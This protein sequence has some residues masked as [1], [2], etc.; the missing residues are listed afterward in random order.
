MGITKKFYGKTLEGADV[1]IF[2]LSNSKGMTADII[3]LG[4]IVVSL[5]VPDKNGKLEDVVLGYDSIEGYLKPG[6]YFGALVGRH[7]NRIE[8]SKFE[9]NGVE[10]SLYKNN[11]ENHLHGGL[12][13]FDKV[14]WQA[15]IIESAGNEEL[16]LT[17]LSKDG[18]EGYPGNLAVKVIYALTEDNALEIKYYAVSDK[19]TV[20][21]LTNHSYFNLSGHASGD[22]LEH[23]IMI[24][25]D[26]F[27]VADK[28]LIPT[29]E[30]RSVKGT[31]MDLTKLTPISAGIKS[32]YDQIVFANG[33]DHNWV[34][35]VSGKAPEKIAEVV[36]NKSG[37]SME[38]FT[39]KPGVQLYTGNFL[40]G[41]EIGKGGVPYNKNS[42]L[43]LETQ[44]FP[45]SL[46]HKHFPSPLF[47]AGQEYKYTTT[48]KFSTIN[49]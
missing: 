36:D 37:R 15:E 21:N 22:V 14:L 17:Y 28:Y 10:Y 27:T 42:G 39:N 24:N 3:N 48:Y 45:N 5:F 29:G 9:I 8:N 23:K 31:P 25:A 35:K 40:D 12:K 32:D 13:G 18:E 2:T 4:G 43:C 30:I 33:Y 1:S 34:L 20:I 49:I 46:N 44:F 16:Q 47:K 26:E 6:P 11:G 38:V 41:S 19:E 7:A